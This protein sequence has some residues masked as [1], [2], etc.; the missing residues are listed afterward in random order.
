MTFRR[1]GPSGM[2][3][4]FPV[5]V[6]FRE[7]C[8]TKD[9]WIGG[10]KTGATIANDRWSKAPIQMLTKVCEAAGL[11]EAF[12]D[13]FGGEPTFEELDGRDQAEPASAIRPAARLSQQGP[14]PVASL[15]E[16]AP[17]VVVPAAPVVAPG[18]PM[19]PAAPVAAPAPDPAPSTP[20]V[21]RV[22]D[23]VDRSQGGSLAAVVVLDTGFF[24]TSRDGEV[25]GV[26][27]NLKGSARRVELVTVPS[28]DPT[29]YPPKIT[30]LVTLDSGEVTP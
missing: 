23:V 25:I 5:T 8:N 15:A 28:S 18:A 11:R 4:E 3:I 2:T 16:A 17:V 27:T 13:E 7:V 29:K 30:E 10:K 22:V 19:I 9:E 14:P 21:G 20:N 24:A 26:A 6:Y 12:P 1:L